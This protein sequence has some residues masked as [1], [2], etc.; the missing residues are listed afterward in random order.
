M[1]VLNFI[2]KHKT[3][4]IIAGIIIAAIILGLVFHQSIGIVFGVVGSAWT[5]IFGKKPHDIDVEKHDTEILRIDKEID[6]LEKE[7][8]ASNN[9]LVKLKGEETAIKEEIGKINTDIKKEVD[10]M[11]LE[12]LVSWANKNM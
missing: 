9:R 6:E 1:K 5:A 11:N 8:E 12:E 3:L 10:G 2:K 4:L 7:I